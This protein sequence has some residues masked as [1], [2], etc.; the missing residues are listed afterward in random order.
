[1]ASSVKRVRLDLRKKPFTVRVM[2]HWHRLAR[3]VVDAPSLE[4]FKARLDQALGSLM[5]LWCPCALQGVGIDGSQEV[6][7]S[8]EDSMIFHRVLESSPSLQPPQNRASCSQLCNTLLSA[9]APGQHHEAVSHTVHVSH[10]EI[11]SQ[12]EKTPK[13]RPS[14]R[15]AAHTRASRTAIIASDLP[16]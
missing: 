1:M 11:P 16:G 5:E 2:R 9:A 10:W 14:A 7:S 3:D 4:A 6:P 13:E 15:A 8:F 12:T